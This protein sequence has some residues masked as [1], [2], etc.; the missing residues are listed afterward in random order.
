MED[1]FQVDLER[2][3]D[4]IKEAE[5]ISILFQMFRKSLVIDIRP[6]EEDPPIIRIAAQ[7]RGPEDRLRYIRRQRPSLPRPTNVTMFPWSKSVDSF[8]RLGI[9]EQLLKR[10]ADTGHPTLIQECEDALEELRRLERAEMVAVV[11]GENYY[12]VWSANS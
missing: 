2:V 12:T 7:S 3:I 11:R 5:V 6:S 4:S 8:V 1:D 9:F 10:A